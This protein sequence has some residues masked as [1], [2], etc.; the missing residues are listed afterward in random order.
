MMKKRGKLSGLDINAVL[1]IILIIFMLL[2]WLIRKG[3]LKV[4]L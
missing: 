3:Y 2:L 4:S 1:I